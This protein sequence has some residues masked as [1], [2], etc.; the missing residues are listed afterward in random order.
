MQ[1]DPL[2]NQEDI[3]DPLKR[4]KEFLG[5]KE[6]SWL[7]NTNI[8]LG[9]EPARTVDEDLRDAEKEIENLKKEIEKLKKEIKDS[10][11]QI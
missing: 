3:Y 9:W 7:Q 10:P 1:K 2:K 6:I 8:D 4:V 5:I 11:S